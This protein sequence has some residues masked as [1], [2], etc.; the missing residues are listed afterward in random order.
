MVLEKEPFRR[1]NNRE[2]DKMEKPVPIRFNGDDWSIIEDCSNI[3]QQKK[4]STTIKFLM[5]VGYKCIKDPKNEYM[6]TTLFKNRKNNERQN[7][8]D[9]D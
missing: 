8:I 3:I 5:K 9:F 7:I 2:L 6:L 4:T 1:Y